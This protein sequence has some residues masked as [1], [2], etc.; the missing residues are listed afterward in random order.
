MLT[1]GSA[2]RHLM[3]RMASLPAKVTLF[4]PSFVQGKRC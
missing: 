2:A 4:R 1:T 3:H